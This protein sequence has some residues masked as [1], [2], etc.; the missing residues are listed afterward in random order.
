[1]SD[2]D[3]L[4]V[5]ASFYAFSSNKD[6]LKDQFVLISPSAVSWICL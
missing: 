4:G 3:T 5:F 1:M 2:A 6:M